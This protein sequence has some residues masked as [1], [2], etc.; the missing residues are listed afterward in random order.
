MH[1]ASAALA[2][3]LFGTVTASA[4]PFA[5]LPVAANPGVATVENR[6]IPGF[7]RRGDGDGGEEAA[8]NRE[9]AME[10]RVQQLEAQVRTLTGQVEEL[11]FMVRQLQGM[12]ASSADR[13]D[14]GTSTGAVVASPGAA[15]GPGA[16]PSDLGTLPASP[17]GPLDLSA[18][19]QG[20]GEP[21]I[22]PEA[23]RTAP[24]AT[25]PELAEVDELL[26]SGRYAMA[27][28][29]ARSVLSGNAGGTVATEARYKLAEALLAQGDYRNAANQFL[30]TYTTNPDGTRAPKSLVGLGT[31]LNGL[32]ERE[33]ACSSLEEL[34]GR[35][36]DVDPALRSEGEAQ[37]RAAGCV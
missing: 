31:A 22:A 32:G 12:A 15:A 13:A 20:L 18:L 5:K 23:P 8:V 24:A 16:P 28:D 11:T 7:L 4:A 2:V 37:Q 3:L 14:A 1:P 27:A 26:R 10:L 6:F 9:A 25:T 36:P 30:E 35:F 29:A 21:T 33:A 17:S 34:F 19:N